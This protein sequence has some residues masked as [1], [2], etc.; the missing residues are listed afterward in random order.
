MDEQAFLPVVCCGK[1]NIVYN[2]LDRHMQ[3]ERRTAVAY[4]WEADVMGLRGFITYEQLYRMTNQFAKD[5]RIWVCK[6]GIV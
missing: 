3:T 2:C 5:C 6:K 4:Y 1:F